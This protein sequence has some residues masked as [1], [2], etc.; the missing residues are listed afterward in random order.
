MV[1]SNG[2]PYCKTTI[3]HFVIDKYLGGYF[4]TMQL[5]LFNISPY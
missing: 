2:F 3:I 4:E 1:V 5:F